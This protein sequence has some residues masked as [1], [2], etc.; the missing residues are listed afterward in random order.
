MDLTFVVCDAET[1]GFSPKN[2]WML[3]VQCLITGDY[4]S[5]VGI[6]NV[7]EAIFRMSEESKLI[8]GHNFL[9]YDHK[10]IKDLSG[11]DLPKDIIVDT[12]QMS[13]DLCKL[14]NHKLETWGQ[15]L[16]LPKLESPLFECYTPEMDTYCERDVRLNTAVFGFLYQMYRT[17]AP[18]GMNHQL[19][20]ILDANQYALSQSVVALT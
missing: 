15:I 17:A 12:L 18:D 19:R 14:K 16:G 8:V 10:V 2:I 3:G 5:F 20:K 11:V 1:D 4:K 13:R 9:G 7:A 6:D